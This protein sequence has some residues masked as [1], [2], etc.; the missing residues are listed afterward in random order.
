LHQTELSLS[1]SILSL[2]YDFVTYNKSRCY[3]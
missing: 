2:K 1:R 3:I